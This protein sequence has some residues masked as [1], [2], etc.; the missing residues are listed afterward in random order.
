MD[1]EIN[2][3]VNTITGDVDW[4]EIHGGVIYVKGNVN[5]IVQHG[6]VM[7]DQRP[8]DRVEFRTE[9]LSE[10]ER[11]RYRRR[12]A[13]LENKLSRSESECLKL[14]E[15]LGKEASEAPSDDVLVAKIEYLQNE[16]ESERADRKRE[17][18]ELHE[19]ID[20]AMEINA[21]LRHK[22]HEIDNRD[23]IIAENHIDI[24]A[25][26]LSLYPF[27]PDKDLVFEFGIPADKISMVAK[28]LGVV[29]S[30]EARREAVEYLRKQHIEFIQ[31]RGG[32]HGGNT[33]II[34]MV[35]RNGRVIKTFKSAVIAAKN[36]GLCDKTIREY[37]QIYSKNR[38]YTKDGYT[39]R[40]KKE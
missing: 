38:R 16:L 40:Y 15:K 13:E 3:G 26:L 24:L 22:N 7:Y 8:S 37:C 18:D 34:E 4:L 35:S 19:R 20:V 27:T 39:F 21:K 12:I 5:E 36:T 32:D 30:P 29:K 1:Y 17:V 6:G 33:P 10:E 23:L 28:I 25:T 9:R 14:R 11:Q 2:G 31:R